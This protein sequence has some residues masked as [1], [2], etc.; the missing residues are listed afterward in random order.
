MTY[1][2]KFVRKYRSGYVRNIIIKKN[3]VL[4]KF[5]GEISG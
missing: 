4:G 3:I 5:K 1:I 2:I